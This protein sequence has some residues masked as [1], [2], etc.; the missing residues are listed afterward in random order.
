MTSASGAV[1]VYNKNNIPDVDEE[2]LTKLIILP[3]GGL[4]RKED[5]LPFI[6]RE[7]ARAPLDPGCGQ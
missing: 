7:K 6:V 5:G 2:T 4:R 3:R 1:I